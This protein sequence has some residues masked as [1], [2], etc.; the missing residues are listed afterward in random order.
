[1]YLWPIREVILVVV[2]FS[3]DVSLIRK[4]AFFSVPNNVPNVEQVSR[5]IQ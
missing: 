4:V 5:S 1:M 3:E 2:T